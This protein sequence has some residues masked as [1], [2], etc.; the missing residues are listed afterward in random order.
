MIGIT[1]CI[2][3]LSWGIFWQMIP[4]NAE[5]KLLDKATEDNKAQAEM[6]PQ[7]KKRV[8]QAKQMV[9]AKAKAWAAYV[10]TRTPGTSLK[11][12]GIDLSVNPWQL[13]VDT[14]KFRDSIQRA[15][16]EQVKKGGIKVVTAP[17]VPLVDSS[18]PANQI[19]DSFYNYPS[20]K[21][22]VVIFDFGTVTVQGTYKQIMDNVRA[23]KSMPHYLAVADGLRID[24][25]S[26]NLTGTYNL[27]IVGFIRT[28]TI[29]PAVNEG[30]ATSAA[31]G[32]GGG[33]AGG[34][35]GMGGPGGMMGGGAGMPPGM[36][37]GGGPSRGKPGVMGASF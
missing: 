12:G 31:G 18:I 27:S 11:D 36:G 4:N 2:G 9:D 6:M 23:Y 3:F 5:V 1:F 7:A 28:K 15:V 10:A 26:P 35:M 37:G 34:R 19:L 16:N 20:I 32:F 30:A 13:V 17:L 33:G 8:E 25:T 21:F 29:A 22:P 14:P 24:G